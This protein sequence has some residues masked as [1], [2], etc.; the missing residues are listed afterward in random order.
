MFRVGVQHITSHH[1]T[2]EHSTH[3]FCDEWFIEKKPL[4]YSTHMRT[5]GP[6]VMPW[7]GDGPATGFSCIALKV[8]RISATGRQ[9]GTP[10]R[11]NSQLS[12]RKV[13]PGHGKRDFSPLRRAVASLSTAH[14]DSPTPAARR[15]RGPVQ[16]LGTL[17]AAP[18]A[19]SSAGS[20][21]ERARARA[22][23]RSAASCS[24]RSAEMSCVGRCTG[25]CGKVGVSKRGSEFVGKWVSEY[26]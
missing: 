3:I 11:V 21:E 17:G 23:R 9:R 14:S 10:A 20:K 19:C 25:R 6:H 2:H 18:A 4:K 5:H 13:Q 26:T 1:A 8:R 16:L 22:P 7:G 12:C 24:L 15:V